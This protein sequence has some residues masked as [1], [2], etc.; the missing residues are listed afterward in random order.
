MYAFYLFFGSWILSDLKNEYYK[1]STHATP[2]SQ[3]RWDTRLIFKWSKVGLNT[4]FSFQIGCLNMAKE[5]S[6]SNYLPIAG[7]RTDV[8]MLFPR[9]LALSETQTTSS[10]IWT[11]VA[12]SISHNNHFSQPL[13]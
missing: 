2:L 12:N 9:A 7:G 1:A 10:R 5:I 13:S 4:E 3:A 11:W 8:F 6:L